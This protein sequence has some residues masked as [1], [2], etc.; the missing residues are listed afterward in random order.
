MKDEEVSFKIVRLYFEEIAR[1]G[2]KRQLDLDQIINS[3]FYTLNKLRNK[4]DAMRRISRQIIE[5]ENKIVRK[6]VIGVDKTVTE[7]TSTTSTG[8]T[9]ATV[10][11]TE[12]VEETRS[13]PAANESPSRSKTITEIIEEEK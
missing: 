8:N 7:T 9:G 11:R 1:L 2:F 10:K 3:Y 13:R 4:E 5:D 12:I 6:E